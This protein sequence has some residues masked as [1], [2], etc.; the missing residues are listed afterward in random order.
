MDR[1]NRGSQLFGLIPMGFE[2]W[3][4]EQGIPVQL[5][6]AIMAEAL[7]AG[8]NEGLAR[9]IALIPEHAEELVDIISTGPE[10]SRDRMEKLGAGARA[11]LIVPT[12][13]EVL[14]PPKKN[15]DWTRLRELEREFGTRTD[16]DDEQ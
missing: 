11:I 2:T 12:S 8:F 16:A 13:P 7:V 14:A 15:H 10:V 5:A 9:A 4:K 1:P 3:L 6:G